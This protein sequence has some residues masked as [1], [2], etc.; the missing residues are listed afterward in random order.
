M[1]KVALTIFLVIFFYALSGQDTLSTL[2]LVRNSRTM[3]IR[4][5]DEIEIHKD[6]FINSIDIESK[7]IVGKYKG[8]IGDSIIISPYYVRDETFPDKKFIATTYGIEYTSFLKKDTVVKVNLKEINRIIYIRKNVPRVMRYLIVSS[9]F[10]GLILSPLF[11]IEK[12]GFNTDRYKKVSITSGTVM[13][14]SY[15]VIT[16]TID[17]KHDLIKLR[18]KEKLWTIQE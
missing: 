2:H 12:S 14:S 1:S 6:K 3:N 17:K 9:L 7:H 15:L 5:L 13:L 16:F 4:L 11:S 10:T 8:V 18:G